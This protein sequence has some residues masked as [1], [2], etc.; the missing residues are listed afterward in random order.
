MWDQAG[1]TGH[2]NAPF[3]IYS[4]AHPVEDVNQNVRHSRPRWVT[5]G[6]GCPWL[7]G[8][9]DGVIMFT[10]VGGR[11]AFYGWGGGGL[12]LSFIAIKPGIGFT[13]FLFIQF[14]TLFP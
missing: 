6:W 10:G 1:A 4:I 9:V 8:S 14:N 2:Q 7:T 12:P 13:I 5:V 11:P 3:Y